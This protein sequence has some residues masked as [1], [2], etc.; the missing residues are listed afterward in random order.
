MAGGLGSEVDEIKELVSEERIHRFLL[1]QVR[2]RTL[3]SISASLTYGGGHFSLQLI[4][5]LHMVFDF[6]AFRSDVGFW[7]GRESMG[8]LSSRGVISS[9]ACTLI[10]YLYLLDADGVNTIVLATYTFSTA[11]EMWKVFRVP[12]VY[13]PCTFPVPSL[14]LPH[15]SSVY[16]PCVLESIPVPSLYLPCTFPVPSP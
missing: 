12:S 6:L 8:G 3:H 14:Y 5:I 7:K 16:S 11:L 10:V 13:L 9:A 1:M 15:R 2:D 4:G